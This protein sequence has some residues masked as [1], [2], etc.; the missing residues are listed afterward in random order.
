MNEELKK[1]ESAAM[2]EKT[3]A[4]VDVEAT[5]VAAS[6]TAST[7][8]TPTAGQKKRR[9]W[10]KAA[11]ISLAVVIVLLVVMF[12]MVYFFPGKSSNS[13]RNWLIHH[14]PFPVAVA[15]VN[16]TWVTVPLA[17]Y[18]DTVA[19]AKHFFQK[20][21]EYGLSIASQ[22]TDA[23]LHEQEYDRELELAYTQQLAKKMNVTVSD[24]D[25]DT[26]FTQTILPQASSEDEISQTLKD[27]YGWTIADFKKSVLYPVVLRQKLNEALAADSSVD[28]TAKAKAEDVLA[29]VKKG[30]KSFEDLAAQYSTD[31][32]S[33]SSGGDLGS[34]GK[35]VMVQPFEDAAF[36]LQVGQVSDLVKTQYGYHIIKLNSRDDAAG[37]VDASHILI[38]FETVDD[39]IAAMKKSATAYKFLPHYPAVQDTSATTNNPYVNSNT[40]ADANVNADTSTN[41]NSADTNVN[42][43]Q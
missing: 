11:M 7:T 38:G 35:G 10:K 17:Q 4:P 31:T 8:T 28:A 12:G 40:N 39:R 2:P 21:T 36:A 16:G 42:A 33:A 34:F 23:V 27:L 29:Q 43:A 26:Y 32:G 9:M 13:V 3:P 6:E 37:T 1:D 30:D 22:P 15:H 19:A 25:V 24:S 41:T 20:Q 5:P 14:L 18:E